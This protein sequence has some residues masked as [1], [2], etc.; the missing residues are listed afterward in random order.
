MKE[1]DPADAAAM[2]EGAEG[3]AADET[4]A[5]LEAE[6]DQPEASSGALESLLDGLMET[7]PS[8]PL[9][10][11]ESVWNPELGGPRRIKRG[12]QKM[13]NTDGTPAIFDI[14]FGIGETFAARADQEASDRAEVND[15]EENGGETGDVL[16]E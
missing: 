6:M 3:A 2:A 8:K 15:L 7:E 16:S 14:A 12:I 4:T 9:S 1:I 5:A 11:V 10:S 13:T